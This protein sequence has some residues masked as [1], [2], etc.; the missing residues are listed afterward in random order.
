MAL[1]N[2]PDVLIADEPTTALDVTVQAQILNLIRELQAAL[3]HG[4]DPDH[5]RPD[6]RP[7]VLRLR[8]RDAARRGER[9]QRD[10][11]SSSP[12]RSIPTPSTCSP[13]SRR[14]SPTR[15]RRTRRIILEGDERARR[16]H[17]EARRLLQAG[18]RRAGRRRQPRPDA[19]APRD[20]RPRRRI[21]LRQ[22]HLRPGADP[23]DQHATA[24]RSSSTAQ[25]HPGQDAPRDAAVPLAHADRLPGSVRL[26]Q[27]AHVDR[28]DHRG[29]ADRQ[30]HRRQ[31]KRAAR[32]GPAGAARRR[33]AGQHPVA[34]PARILRRPA[35]AHRHR[36]RHRARAGVHPA[37]RADLGARPL[38]AGADHRPP[39]QAA[40]RAR[41]ELPLHLARPEGRARALPP[42]H[43]HAARQDRRTGPGRR[44]PDPIPRPPTP[45]G[46]SGPPSKSPPNVR[47]EA[48]SWQDNPK[49]PSSA[50]VRPCS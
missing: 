6:H 9:A 43:G 37:R 25:P 16:L 11:S 24:A 48:P 26:A 36:P 39:A 21:G 30:R 12:A 46:S 27:S 22:D 32:A 41:P 4:G 13:P 42:R 1:A 35:P 29:R 19:A 49:S 18:L 3:R 14:A 17:A 44:G 38:G 40:G 45:N 33:H 34:L 5:P 2:R 10:R 31:R 20:P 8:L 28:P 50:P 7:A 15:C 47:T 23:A